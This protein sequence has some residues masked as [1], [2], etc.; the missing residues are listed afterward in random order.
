MRQLEFIAQFTTD[1]H[2]I[3]GSLNTVSDAL[4]LIEEIGLNNY[5][6]LAAAQAADPELIALLKDP[7]TA[8]KLVRQP[9]PLSDCELVVD[10]STNQ[11]RPYLPE[12]FRWEV[13]DKLHNLSHPGVRATKALVTARFALPSICKDC[14]MWTRACIRCQRCKVHRNTKS[15][16]ELFTVPGSRFAHV[17]APCHNPAYLVRR[18][19]ILTDNG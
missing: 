17:H 19:F 15:P 4:S 7:S 11:Q 9:L 8:F 1:I 13:F 5:D 12:G 6:A 14:T 18:F 10:T 2:R 3:P 16:P